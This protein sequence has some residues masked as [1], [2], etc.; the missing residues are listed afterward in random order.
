MQIF[1]LLCI[2]VSI[3]G[4]WIRNIVRNKQTPDIEPTSLI[5]PVVKYGTQYQISNITVESHI[6]EYVNPADSAVLKQ[7]IVGPQET[8]TV[9]VLHDTTVRWITVAA[10]PIESLNVD[11]IE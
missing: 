7:L 11:C 8:I 6:V 1:I 10:G 2:V 4:M 3:V 9:C 5:P